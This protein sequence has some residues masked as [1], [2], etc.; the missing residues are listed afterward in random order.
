M[1]MQWLVYQLTGSPWMLGVVT[2]AGQLPN[3]LLS[4][5]GGVLADSHNRRR[6]LA[7]SQGAQ[8]LQALL[9]AGLTLAGVVEVWHLIVLSLM[10]GL[11]EAIETPAR[12][13]LMVE[14]VADRED[15][16]NAIALNSSM[17]N[18]A[19][20][21]GPAV[22]GFIIS[23]AGAGLCFL[24]NATTYLAVLFAVH[25]LRLP[26]RPMRESTGEGVLTRL[27]A[28]FGYAWN[29]RAIRMLLLLLTTTSIASMPF[30]T[31][32]PVFAEDVLQGDARTL[33][34]L[35][36][37]TG[38]GALAGA[39]FLASRRAGPAG[40]ERSLPRC[41]GAFALGLVALGFSQHL[42]LALPIIA[43]SGFAAMVQVA[44]TNTL[45]QSLV[46]DTMRGR[47]MG[48]YATALLGMAPFGSLISGAVAQFLGV[49]GAFVVGG[50][51]LGLVWALISRQLP[52]IL[53]E[54]RA[55]AAAMEQGRTNAN[56]EMPDVVP[57]IAPQP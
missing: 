13:A 5:V 35:M 16:P 17:F 31:L 18:M 9:L 55:R 21:I 38:V 6:L 10:L 14:L 42:A 29:H 23:A 20:L 44:S 53:R 1:A 19:R 57:A 25:R 34:F 40:L 11:A 43:A 7:M 33:G 49:S 22:A 50:I 54:A 28:G 36:S 3:F 52:A 24:V 2:F 48:L 39:L 8:M 37:A 27:R 47:V 45:I 12:Q 26:A 51:L 41:T 15:L 30:Y 56:R 32:M 46:S 4:T